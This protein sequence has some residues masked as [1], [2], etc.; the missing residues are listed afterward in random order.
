MDILDVGLGG[1]R[2][3]C[4]LSITIVTASRRVLLAYAAGRTR[5]ADCDDVADDS[6]ALLRYS[7]KAQRS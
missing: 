1:G 4:S 6:L 7:K 3:Q 5:V 2:V